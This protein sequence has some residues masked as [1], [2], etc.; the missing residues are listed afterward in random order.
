MS[1]FL[2]ALAVVATIYGIAGV[3]FPNFLLTN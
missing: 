3:L 1:N 2:K